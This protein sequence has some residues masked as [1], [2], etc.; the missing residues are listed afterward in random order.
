MSLEPI[1][2][3]PPGNQLVFPLN[4]RALVAGWGWLFFSP[5]EFSPNPQKSTEWNRGA[6]LVE[7]PGH[8]GACHTPK[9]V[10]GADKSSKALQG[11]TIQDWTAPSLAA[12]ERDGLGRWSK[13]DIAEYLKTGRNRFSGATGLMAEVV[14]NSTSKMTDSDLKAMAVY[15]KDLPSAGEPAAPPPDAAVMA[16]GRAIYED[17]CSACHGPSGEGVPHMFP[18]LKGD[19]VAQQSDP[20]TVLRVI[21]QG[22]MTAA[23][24]ERPTPSAMPAFDWKL[25]DEQIA[26]V[27]TY[28]RNSWGNQSS[29][30]GAGAVGDL[31]NAVS[32]TKAAPQTVGVSNRVQEQR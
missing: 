12:D 28:V 4:F 8:C 27:A 23:T 15:L 2:N 29:P 24:R 9:N 25:S 11:A 18:P 21:L 16:V 13:D 10:F 7:G 5:G 20:S 14:V 1:S 26:A 19:A 6:Y 3:T 31:R 22:A 30:V 17:S 32:A